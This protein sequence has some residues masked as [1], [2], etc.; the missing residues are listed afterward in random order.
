M[1]TLLLLCGCCVAAAPTFAQFNVGV[2]LGLAVRDN[3]AFA[4][5]LDAADRTPTPLTDEFG[6][7]KFVPSLGLLLGY[8]GDVL[9]VEGGV[10]YGFS[11]VEGSYSEEPGAFDYT[12]RSRF[13]AVAVGPTVGSRRFEISPKLELTRSVARLERAGSGAFDRKALA[14]WTPGL[15]LGATVHVRGDGNSHL[16]LRPF[17]RLA[18]GGLD[19][20]G[21]QED[22]GFRT[23]TTRARDQSFG[24]SVI[25]YNGPQRRF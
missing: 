5:T 7:G 19:Y 15:D 24:L 1:R 21:L 16:A 18:L 12:L 17:Y 14:A 3:A 22:F 20:A 23:A 13:L 25:I 4:A 9:G 6:S 8:R 2:A 11:N 10:S